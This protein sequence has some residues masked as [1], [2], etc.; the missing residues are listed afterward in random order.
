MICILCFNRKF[1]KQL[2]FLVSSDNHPTMSPATRVMRF[3]VLLGTL[4]FYGRFLCIAFV[5]HYPRDLAIYFTKQQFS[6]F[7][8]KLMAVTI[9]DFY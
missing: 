7:H 4:P 6:S 5:K 1:H 8:I 9:S 3:T 2:F